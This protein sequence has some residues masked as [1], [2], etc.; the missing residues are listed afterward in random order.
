MRAAM[1]KQYGG[2][3]VL[4]FDEIPDPVPGEGE[5]LVRVHATT[6]NRTDTAYRSGRPWINRAVCGWPRPRNH[7][8][9]SEYAGVVVDVG[10]GVES[11]DVGDRVFGFVDGRPGAHAEMVVV[12]VK[13]LVARI[14]EGW[15]FAEAAAGMEGAHYA[16]ATLRATGVSADDRVLVHGATGG[17]GSAAVQLLHAEGV[18]V[19]AVCDRL[20]TDRRDLLTSLGAAHAVDLSEGTPLDSVGVGF[21]V[22]FAATGHLSFA[23]ARR[24]L[25][26]GGSYVSS[27]LGRGGHNL[28]LAAVG[29]VARGL[30]R[31][32]V[33]FPFPHAGAD[34]AAHIAGLMDRGAY[35]PLIDR[36]YAFEDL[37]AAHAY[38]DSG[39]KVGNVVV[40]LPDP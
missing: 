40:T 29:P 13:G 1:R 22:V 9:G 37:R 20:P 10:D 12:P 36:T 11:Y 31:R 3:E 17:I 24:L 30:G 38:V 15:E 33:K 4:T 8:L 16:H 5:M 19:T 39:R 14:P 23:A 21:D 18:E 26:P 32:R 28:L 27:E 7:V 2:P 35:R 25:E 6:V 34:L